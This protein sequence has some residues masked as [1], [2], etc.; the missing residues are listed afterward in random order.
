MEE[1]TMRKEIAGFKFITNTG[2][3]SELP[4]VA[5]ANTAPVIEEKKET[6][7]MAEKK[8]ETIEVPEFMKSYSARRRM[9]VKA[10]AEE[11]AKEANKVV[12][13]DFGKEEEEETDPVVDFV[14]KIESAVRKK[15]RNSRIVKFFFDVE[16][17]VDG[18]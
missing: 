14:D 6:I 7:V 8:N 2:F 1:L 10:R 9:E 12:Y 13:V 18:E 15:V 11:E 4:R 3:H 16:D 5:M 17:D